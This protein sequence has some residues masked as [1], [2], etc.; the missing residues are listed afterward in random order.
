MN[1]KNEM[2]TF[3]NKKSYL[4][5][6]FCLNFYFLPSTIHTDIRETWIK[7][8]SQ[9]VHQLLINTFGKHQPL[10]QKYEAHFFSSNFSGFFWHMFC[11]TTAVCTWKQK[12]WDCLFTF[13]S[14]WKKKIK[15][16]AKP[17]KYDKSRKMKNFE[18]IDSIILIFFEKSAF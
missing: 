18:E 2:S 12:N 7:R 5:L 1:L 14:T 11:R 6:T 3:L 4:Y 8:K 13:F 16:E 17:K 15:N 10:F 9:A